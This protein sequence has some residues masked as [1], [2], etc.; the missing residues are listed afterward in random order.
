MYIFIYISF[1]NTYFQ[2]F[3]NQL[4]LPNCPTKK[5]HTNHHNTYTIQ[6]P[7]QSS[8]AFRIQS[9]NK[10]KIKYQML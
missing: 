5:N 2:L 6:L 9:T 7:N 8:K 4:L 1:I 3:F 10:P